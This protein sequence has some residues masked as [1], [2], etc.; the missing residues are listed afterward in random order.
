MA[1]VQEQEEF[2]QIVVENFFRTQ[3]IRERKDREKYNARY[4]EAFRSAF[5]ALEV[6][7]YTEAQRQGKRLKRKCFLWLL[8]AEFKFYNE[9]FKK[10]MPNS[11][12][13]AP[14]FGCTEKNFAK[15]LGKVQEKLPKNKFA[16]KS[17]NG[18]TA[19][20]EQEA[21]YKTLSIKN[22][23]VCATMSA[24]KST[25]VNALLGRDVL[26][27]R[28]EATT[29]K[30]TSVYDKDGS[31]RMVGFVQKRGGEVAEKNADVH[32]VTIDSWNSSSDVSR[33]YLQGDLD[34]IGNKGIIAAM[35]DTPG[36]NNSGDKSHHDVTLQFLK[37]N[38]MDALI[39][40]ANAEQ[41]CTTDE[42]DLLSE[43]LKNVVLPNK[44]PVFFVLN[45]ADAI[46]PEKEGLDDSI[47]GYKKYLSELGFS[48]P[49]VF[50]VSAKAARLLKMAR[51]GRTTDFTSREARA[52]DALY[53]EFSEL[54][55]FSGGDA[56]A[57]AE[58]AISGTVCVGKNEYSLATVA[59]A[60]ERTGLPRVEQ[61][62]EQL[63]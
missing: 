22:I 31:S 19:F 4:T 44:T 38:K 62:I 54:H 30:I 37:E 32:L 1:I 27:S 41:L 55:D 8:Y 23:A 36:T 46:D 60:L 15:F 57:S 2:R 52:F 12:E 14:V 50:P 7:N 59:N 51:N 24:G 21:H 3:V 18:F 61:Y 63:F 6:K 25:F 17:Y 53:S 29:A 35:H 34:G 58:P 33:I 13:L 11:N 45:K 16:A 20:K 48:S 42:R 49:A 39:F 10:R 47:S 43:L 26:P 5:D 56:P 9:V 28:N 40:I